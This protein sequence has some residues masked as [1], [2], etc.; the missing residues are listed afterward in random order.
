MTGAHCLG[1]FHAIRVCESIHGNG[2]HVDYVDVYEHPAYSNRSLCAVPS[3]VING[4]TDIIGARQCSA[5]PEWS[6][7]YD[8]DA[9]DGTVIRAHW[10]N[11]GSNACMTIHR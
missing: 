9:D 11:E 7:H 6:Y 3:I 4:K 1:P 2:L 5:Q 10:S 8:A